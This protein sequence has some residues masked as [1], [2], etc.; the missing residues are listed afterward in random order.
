M[1]WKR[2]APHSRARSSTSWPSQVHGAWPFRSNEHNGASGRSGY[3]THVALLNFS[4]NSWFSRL[5]FIGHG[6]TEFRKQIDKSS[7]H[8]KIH[9]VDRTNAALKKVLGFDELAGKCGGTTG[10]KVV[11]DTGENLVQI[12]ADKLDL[13]G[14]RKGDQVDFQL[15][16]AVDPGNATR[17]KGKVLVAIDGPDPSRAQLDAA[18]KAAELEAKG[19]RRPL[20]DADPVSDLIARRAQLFQE[21]RQG[22]LD[23]DSLRDTWESLR[24]EAVAKA[25]NGKGSI[26][27]KQGALQ[28]LLDIGAFTPQEAKDLGIQV[29]SNAFEVP[30]YLPS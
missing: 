16:S 7:G 17:V 3:K 8:L 4:R 14:V 2:Q 5:P 1:P 21:F 20:D 12:Q 10:D 15:D 29:V 19:I 30:D 13:A 22:V 6:Q 28:Q 9:E 27:E 23:Q 25:V 11:V 24:K 26:F 18:H